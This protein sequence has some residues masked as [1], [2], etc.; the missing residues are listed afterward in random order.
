[1]FRPW[2]YPGELREQR[3]DLPHDI[4]SVSSIS[5]AVSTL[6]ALWHTLSQHLDNFSRKCTF[7]CDS[8]CEEQEWDAILQMMCPQKLLA[9]YFLYQRS[10]WEL[11]WF[12]LHS[13]RRVFFRYHYLMTGNINKLGHFFYLFD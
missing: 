12:M 5:L 4:I 7:L 1:L 8:Y 3:G 9:I 2:R 10:Y 11:K 6:L 13:K